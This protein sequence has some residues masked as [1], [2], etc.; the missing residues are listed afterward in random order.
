MKKYDAYTD[1]YQ[2]PEYSNS[3]YDWS[4]Y[5]QYQT[6]YSANRFYYESRQRY[7][8]NRPVDPGNQSKYE[9]SQPSY[10]ENA[11]NYGLSDRIDG[12]RQSYTGS[13]QTYREA[14]QNYEPRQRHQDYQP[15]GGQA[16]Q[17]YDWDPTVQ[18]AF[19]AAQ[20]RLAWRGSRERRDLFEQFEALI[21]L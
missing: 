7:Q 6:P 11:S 3:V 14:Q 20:S 15:N 13:S 10:Q 17:Q 12:N 8:D 16:T 2:K 5:N 1:A 18:R 21:N 9:K 19:S 4:S